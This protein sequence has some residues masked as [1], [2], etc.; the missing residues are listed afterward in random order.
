MD[1]DIRNALATA[2]NEAEA[3]REEPVAEVPEVV[4]EVSETVEEK[5][6]RERDEKG[7]FAAKQAEEAAAAEVAEVAPVEEVAP[8]VQEKRAPNTWR[9]E[10]AAQW[11][12]LPD[13]IKDEILKRESDAR[14]GIQTYKQAADM[15]RTFEEAAKPFQRQFEE[16]GVTPVQAFQHLLA[17]DHKLRYSSPQEKAQYFSEL[18]RTYGIDLQQV[19]P[20]PPIP[21]EMLEMQRE[22]AQ[23]RQAQERVTQQQQQAL[24]TE[25][26]QFAEAH[27]HFEIVKP[28]MAVL[29]QNG[30][31]ANLQDAYEKAIWADPSIRSQMLQQ[32]AEQERKQAQTAALTQRQKAAAVSVKGSSPASGS[33]GGPKNSLRDELYAA[34]GDHS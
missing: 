6:D 1:D 24:G 14:N 29:L 33:S 25:I 31:A 26:E 11:A 12:T 5:A 10:A 19:Q 32:Q 7:R 28:A 17:A 4:E 22:L 2:F 23:L 20:L 13:Q 15:G 27:E 3:A 8:V 16:L 9:K 18:A 30:Q 21:P 34:F